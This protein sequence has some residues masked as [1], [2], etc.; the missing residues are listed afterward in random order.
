MKE[1][2]FEI[3]DDENFAYGCKASNLTDIASG[4]MKQATTPSRYDQV[5]N[6]PI[7]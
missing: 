2:D 3:G 6:T 1:D 4:T 5:W 7:I